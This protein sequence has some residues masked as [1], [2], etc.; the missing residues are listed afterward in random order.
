MF[1]T[2][3]GHCIL[4][5][6]CLLSL[7]SPSAWHSPSLRSSGWYRITFEHD[8]SRRDLILWYLRV[9][10]DMKRISVSFLRVNT[11]D[12]FV[13]MRV[14]LFLFVW[15]ER[16]SWSSLWN[17]YGTACSSVSS[18]FLASISSCLVP[19]WWSLILHQDH[20]HL[21]LGRKRTTSR[22]IL[23]SK[24]RKEEEN[25]GKKRRGCRYWKRRWS[26]SVRMKDGHDHLSVNC[27]APLI[28]LNTH[29]RHYNHQLLP[30]CESVSGSYI[31]LPSYRFVYL[32]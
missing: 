32:F 1:L 23:T 19:S 2:S 6:F 7:L 24:Q 8:K 29:H 17:P 26:V 27:D 20:H 25:E 3:K 9:T 18:S 4:L 16:V 11:F 15:Y 28:V 10:W 5:A 31:F 14:S 30:S 12:C 22:G 21:F 13:I